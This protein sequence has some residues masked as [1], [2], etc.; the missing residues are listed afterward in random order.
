MLFIDTYVYIY[1]QIEYQM[2]TINV[3]QS[4]HKYS[5]TNQV[6]TIYTGEQVSCKVISH[7]E[8]K[9]NLL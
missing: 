2:K 9:I 6:L 5:N 4:D 7:I 8:I 1:L 3:G